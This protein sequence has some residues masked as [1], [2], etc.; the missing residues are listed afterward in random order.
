MRVLF[1]TQPTLGH[2][3]PL[4]PLAKALESAGHEIVF[5][6][7][8]GFC[9]VI[10]AKG[11][12]CFRAGADLGDEEMRQLRARIAGPDGQLPPLSMLTYVF[13]GIRAERT[14][15]DMMNIMGDWR[16]DVVVR[17]NLEFTGCIAAEL[18]GIPHATFQVTA[19]WPEWL[20]TLE[21]PFIRLCESVG[22]SP[23]EKPADMLYRYLMLFPRPHSLWNAELRVPPTR[24]AFRYTG[25][26]RSGEEALP[27]WFA[28]LGRRPLVYATLGTVF[29][30][31]TDI[32][33]AILEGLRYEQVNLILTV[34]RNRDPQEFAEQPPH[35]RIE[36]YIP[37]SLLLPYCDLVISHGGS[38]TIMD[39]L[40]HGLPMVIIPIDADQPE[41]ARRC[42]DVDVASVIEPDRRTP[43]AIRGAAREVLGNP[44]YKQA[45]QRLRGEI[46]ELPGLQYPVALLE[47][48]AT[49]RTPLILEPA[50]NE[51]LR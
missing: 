38:G 28:E 30:R 12:R 39:A 34:G 43:E 33:A 3:H 40:E 47:R 7:E 27:G 21:A 48:L 22:L 20:Q 32:L 8:P 11:F 23:P 6:S 19:P 44:R 45:A 9:P 18:A 24:H 10:E 42:A 46:D 15:P 17:D 36:R 13:A 14:L 51:I 49:E 35:I 4:V 50:M 31:L 29:N 5:V 2:W 16:P 25:F 1:T 41:N 37:Q 26:N